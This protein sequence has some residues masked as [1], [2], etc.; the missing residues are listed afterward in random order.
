[1]DTAYVAAPFPVRAMPR[2]RTFTTPTSTATHR[3]SLPSTAAHAGRPGQHLTLP[4]A[5]EVPDVPRPSLPSAE[6][7]R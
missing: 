7:P 6:R 3:G 5:H 4:L 2:T 1:M